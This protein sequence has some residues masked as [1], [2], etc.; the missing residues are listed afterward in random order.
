M[1]YRFGKCTLDTQTHELYRDGHI[2]PLQPKVFQVLT[3]LIAHRQRLVTK[4]ELLEQVWSQQFVHDSVIARCI[5]EARKAIGNREESPHSII[6]LRS[7]GYRFTAD[8]TDQVDAAGTTVS[9]QGERSEWRPVPLPPDTA[10][11]ATVSAQGA[12]LPHAETHEIQVS[13]LSPLSSV[14]DIPDWSRISPIPT[15]P[16]APEALRLASSVHTVEC[17]W[18]TVLCCTLVGA[19]VMEE[20]HA[21][22]RSEEHTSELQS[23]RHLVCRLL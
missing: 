1:I 19:T 23:L 11:G 7:Q 18:V 12:A 20:S 15:T 17:K 8:V 16:A 3:Y 10:L 5:M 13:S 9:V 6:T 2:V 4:R 21:P 22:A 14:Q